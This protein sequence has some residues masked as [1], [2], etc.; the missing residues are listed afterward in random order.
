MRHSSV[1]VGVLITG[2]YLIGAFFTPNVLILQ[3]FQLP[4]VLFVLLTILL[5]FWYLLFEP[6]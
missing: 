3:M 6:A 4:M 5:F 1:V 2:R